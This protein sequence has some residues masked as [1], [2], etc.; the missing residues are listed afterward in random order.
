LLSFVTA[1]RGYPVEWAVSLEKLASQADII[2]KGTVVS[3]GEVQDKWFEPYPGFVAR[4]TQFKVVSILKG[5]SPGDKLAFR[6]YA[7]DPQPQGYMFQPQFY[8]FETGRTYLVF[9]TYGGSVG[10]FRQVWKYHKTKEDQGIFLCL[11]GKPV[12][13]GTLKGVVWH[14]LTTMLASPHANDAVYAIRQID[15]MSAGPDAFIGLSDFDRREVVAGVRGLMTNR[16]SRIAEAAIGLVGSHN[17]YMS[18]ERTIYWLATVGSGD[19]PGIG[20]MN[21]RMENIGGE[22]YWKDLVAIA[23]SKAPDETRALAILALG[24]VREPSLE[25]L[26]GR[27]LTDSAPTVRASAA[28]LLAD[29]PSPESS[30]HLTT[31][32]GDAAPEVRAYVARAAGFAQRIEMVGVLAKLL[33]DKE[34]KVRQ[35]AAMSL[36][37]FS[38]KNEGIAGVFRS[39]LKNKEFQP[40]FLIALAREKPEDYL[41]ALARAVEE[42]TEPRNFWGGQIPAFAAWEIL[43]QYLQS[44]PVDE[45]RSGRLNRYL[46]AMEKVGNYSSSEPRDI[47]AFYLQHDMTERAQKFRRAANSAA[48]YDLDYYFKQVDPNPSLYRRER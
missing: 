42:K 12:T 33:A 24:L 26:I 8:H 19:I 3:S 35:T 1:A 48:S 39:Q 13:V 40:L 15:Q 38:P 2:F 22:L 34:P 7:K 4:E 5:E 9:A 23:D 47:Y 31:L 14:E 25:K 45:V 11:N 29:F 36:L 46:D 37:S 21:P 27:W 32:A 17:P 28:L 43:F 20:K 16:E 6:H 30:K 18:E 44:R 41:D 10:V